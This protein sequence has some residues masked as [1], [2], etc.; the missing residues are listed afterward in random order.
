MFERWGRQ[1][2]SHWGN[3]VA[4]MLGHTSHP[5]SQ[6]HESR[7]RLIL[8]WAA[9]CCGIHMAQDQCTQLQMILARIQVQS[10]EAIGLYPRRVQIVNHGHW[11]VDRGHWTLPSVGFHWSSTEGVIEVMLCSPSQYGPRSS[12]SGTRLGKG[13]SGLLQVLP[14]QDWYWV[15]CL[16]LD[17]NLFLLQP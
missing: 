14:W 13:A 15:P 9:Y 11:P 7:S 6:T 17:I 5:P 10:T 16:R 12:F 3:I 1:T 4:A 8:L 2:C